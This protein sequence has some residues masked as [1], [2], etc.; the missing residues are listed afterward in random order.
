MYQLKIP[1]NQKAHIEDLVDYVNDIAHKILRDTPVTEK[2]LLVMICL[3]L[4]DRLF[5][6]QKSDVHKTVALEDEKQTL[7][8]LQDFISHTFD[9]R[10]EFK[11]RLET[12][13][14][15]FEALDKINE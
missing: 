1:V 15:E 9:R 4:A 6:E 3:N 14:L 8:M 11:Q 10:E 5:Q 2:M 12:L 13:V 7:Q